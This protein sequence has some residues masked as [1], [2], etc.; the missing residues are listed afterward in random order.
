MSLKEN[1]YSVFTFPRNNVSIRARLVVFGRLSTSCRVVLVVLFLNYETNQISCLVYLEHVQRGGFSRPLSTII[2]FVGVE[3]RVTV[4]VGLLSCFSHD[5][6]QKLS[7]IANA[8]RCILSL[9][10]IMT[11]LDFIISK[12]LCKIPK[13][14]CCFFT[15]TFLQA[16][17]FDKNSMNHD[18][19][20]ICSPWKIS[21]REPKAA[22]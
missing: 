15:F 2:V 14:C 5:S 3:S 16:M 20:H 19:I 7:L 21:W 1:P 4:F 9:T 12:N 13:C 11:L 8:H 6:S 22:E 10:S 17:Q 18:L